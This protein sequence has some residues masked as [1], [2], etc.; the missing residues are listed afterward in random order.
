MTLA[1]APTPR[2]GPPGLAWHGILARALSAC[3]LLWP[4][5]GRRPPVVR[6]S[7]AWPDAVHR[8]G[9]EYA[10]L[11]DLVA[12]RAGDREAGQVLLVRGVT[13]LIEPSHHRAPRAHV[14]GTGTLA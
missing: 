12:Q 7:A 13:H 8:P 9:R 1:A 2:L 4:G 14:K 11:V 3:L 5:R 6:I 10:P